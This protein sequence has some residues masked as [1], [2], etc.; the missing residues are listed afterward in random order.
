MKKLHEAIWHQVDAAETAGRLDVNFAQGLSANE[1]KRRQ[2]EFGLNQMTARRGTPAWVKFLQ[3]FNQALVYILLAATVVS[4]LL[5]EWVDAAVIFGVVFINAV[6]GFIQESKAEKAIEALAKMVRTEAT[7]RRDGRKQRVPSAELVPGDVVL[8]QSGDSVP[9]DLRF[10]EVRSLQV[11]EAA[12]TGESVPT[13]KNAQPLPADTVL[14]DRKNLGFAGTLVTYGQAEGVVFATGDRTEMGRIATMIHEA[15]DLSTPLTR[16]IAEFSRLLLYVILGLAALTF[17]VGVLRGESAADMFMAAVALAVGAIPEG[18]PAAV[19]ITLAIGVARMAKRN[20]IIRKMP[21]VETLGSTTVIC[22]DKTGTLTENQMTVSRIWAGGHAFEVTGGG[23][24]P[25]GEIQRDGQKVEGKE[26]PALNETLLAGLL[27]NDSQLVRT[28]GRLKVEGDP[29][30][31]ALIVAAQKAGLESKE[32][33]ERLPRADVIPFESEHMFMATL[34]RAAADQ[35][36]YKKGSVERLLE[37]C[38]KVLDAAGQESPLD[39]G[40]VNRAVDEM[41]AQGLRVLA[42]ARRRA[43]ADLAKLTHDDVAGG[44]TLLGLQ[45]MIDPPRAEAIRAVADCQSAGI[46]VKMITGDHKGTAVAIGQQLGLRGGKGSEGQPVAITGRELEEIPD[47]QLPATAERAAVFARVAPEQKL[48][49]V[50]ALQSRGH[51][52]AMTGDGVNDAP[53]LK[54][55]D[56]GVA[57]G[58]TGTDVSKG[59]ADMILTDD[60]FASIEA[61]VEE[62]RNVFDNLTKFIAWTMP[63]NG[64]EGLLILASVLLGTSLPILPVQLLWVNMGTALL[65][66]LMLVFEP[67]EAGIMSRPPR[68]PAQPILTAELLWRIV[69]VSG[70]MVVG[71]F[72]LFVIE[73]R[74]GASLPEARTVVVNVIVMVEIFYLLNCRS[75]TRPFFSL[76]I[77]SNLWMNQAAARRRVAGVMG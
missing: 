77:F 19:T 54:Q 30:E 22:S 31:A 7:V 26:H 60:N 46:E 21:A 64:G 49:L 23:Y 18:L 57:M 73:R 39:A 2:T 14:G 52:V 16:K 50:R 6:V 43:P 70:V 9:A 1:V 48:R 35:V 32:T 29:T 5:G 25:N 74:A 3:Q 12:L 13:Q 8:L 17:L 38:D 15:V 36:I 27:C 10:F 51:I 61:A 40:A 44:L 71:A 68:E 66:G 42:F 58:I 53:A 47:D 28:E 4:A 65:L 45:G 34:H 55:A 41:T 69:L 72:A 67:K 62:G 63:T 75:L 24:E 76:G 37:R 59:A 56:I 33:S 20:A 11:E